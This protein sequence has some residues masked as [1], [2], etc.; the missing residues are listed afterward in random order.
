MLQDLEAGK[1]ME[2]E[3]MLGAVIELAELTEV[4][5]PAL[6][7]LFACVSLLDNTV[8]QEKI[9]IRGVPLE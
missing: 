2:I 5:V 4:Q 8:R 6:K 3:S 1:P 7:A 9:R